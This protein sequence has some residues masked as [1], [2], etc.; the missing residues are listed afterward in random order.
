MEGHEDGMVIDDSGTVYYSDPE[1]VAWV[2]KMEEAARKWEKGDP[3]DE[4]DNEEIQ[5]DD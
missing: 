5:Q 1:Q 2:K 3:G 4:E